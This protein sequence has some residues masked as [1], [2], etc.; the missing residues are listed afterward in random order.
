MSLF[1]QHV[2]VAS[3][4]K[5]VQNLAGGESYQQDS[6]YTL[7]IILLTSFVKDDFYRSADQT[8]QQ[9]KELIVL[10]G[11]EFAAKAALYA[12]DKGGMRSITHVVAGEIA[13]NV[14]G[15]SWTRDFFK[16]VF[17]R[18]DDM[19]EVVAYVFHHKK[20]LSNA[21]R[22]AIRD[23]LSTLSA[24]SLAKY[25]NSKKEV[26][27]VD[28]VNLAHPKYT[29]ALT[30]LV[31]G[32]LK[33]D[34]TWEARI[35][36]AK[37]DKEKTIGEWLYLVGSNKLGYMALLRNLRNIEQLHNEQLI[38]LAC[39]ALTNDEVIAKSRVFPFQFDTAYQA[40][41]DRRL[42][43]A[44]AVACDIAVQNIPDFSG[45]TLIAL[46][47]SA[48]MNTVKDKAFFLAASLFKR[49]NSTLCTFDHDVHLDNKISSIDS[50][51]GIKDRID[52]NGGGTDFNAILKVPNIGYE[53]LIIIS[54]MQGWLDKNF[55][56][57]FDRWR[58]GCPIKVHSFDLTGYG[59][60]KLP[61]KDVYA[62][63]GYSSSIFDVMSAFEED[64][65][66]MITAIENFSNF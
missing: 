13:M 19:L 44:L 52:F 43:K 2:A 24:Y 26:S 39:A 1:N 45:K 7:A 59:T 36:A 16:R 34:D 61:E 11:Y 37:G 20:K 40:I 15:A 30:S 31:K 14:H 46:D 38:Q 42:Q 53:R 56:N 35:S 8:I 65:N 6:K 58:A 22:R 5:I 63:G 47:V 10:T 12:R 62:Y 54:D 4:T 32:T 49:V 3:R 66:A 18:P 17:V 27:M 57:N 50:I 29:E 33:N 9:I 21:L 60:T 55:K 28:L 23:K 64:K 51:F 41:T 25:K 48:S